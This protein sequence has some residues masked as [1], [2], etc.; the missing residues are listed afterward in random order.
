MSK[1]HVHKLTKL[2]NISSILSTMH[3][4]WGTSPTLI[5]YFKAY[6][7]IVIYIFLTAHAILT[8][9]IV[10][11]YQTLKIGLNGVKQFLLSC[12]GIL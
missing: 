11:M 6:S 7:Q 5:F 8:K 2:F 1:T 10:S 4:K 9:L 3:L 12:C